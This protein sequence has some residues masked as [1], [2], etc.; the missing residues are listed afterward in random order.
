MRM[1]II[2]AAAALALAACTPVD[3]TADPNIGTSAPAGGEPSKAAKAKPAKPKS[4]HTVVY[5]IGGTATKALITYATPS[6]QE[7][8]NGA[9]VPWRKTLRTKDFEMLSISA[10]NQGGGTITCEIE[11]DGK[12]VKRSKSTGA[13]AIAMCTATIG[14]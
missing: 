10:Q 9:A 7:Q 13:Y 6:G 3:N 1:F 8:K 14:F 5:R 2:A 4:G 11:V 12:L